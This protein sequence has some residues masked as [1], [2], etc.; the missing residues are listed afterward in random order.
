M[1]EIYFQWQNP[2]LR[3]TIYP[4]RKQKLQ[5][6]LLYFKE[7]DLWKQVGRTAV[8]QTLVH[9]L[10]QM[11][12][13]LQGRLEMAKSNKAQAETELKAAAL[14]YREVLSSRPVQILRSQRVNLQIKVQSLDNKMKTVKRSYDWYQE[15]APEHPYYEKRKREYEDSI[16]PY[17]EAKGELERVSAEYQVALGPFESETA[18]LR[19]RISKLTEE[20]KTLSARLKSLPPLSKQGEVSASAAVRWQMMKYEESLSH[21]GQ[22][23]LIKVI[24]GEFKRRPDRFPSW[25]QY[26]II[27]FSGMRYRSAHGS[28][29]NPADLLEA[30]AIDDLKQKIDGLSDSEIEG[31]CQ[32]VIA[33]LEAK[34]QATQ[35]RNAIRKIDG[36]ISR[37]NNQWARKRKLLELLSDEAIRGIRQLDPDQALEQLRAKKDRFPAWAWKEVV[38]R[39]NLRVEEASD[40]NWEELSQK[41]RQES[42]TR[43]NQRWMSML[44][45]WKTK[46]ITQWRKQHEATL[47]LIV[48]RAVCNEVSE[49]IQHLRGV[50]PSA[51]LTSKPV[52]Y[53][54]LQ[55][56]DPR[57]SYFKR[58]T[59]VNDLKQ[60][61][62]ILW[63]GWVNREPNAWQIA[64]P[65][66]GI[67][68]VP[69]AEVPKKVRKRNVVKGQ[70]DDWRYMIE[71]DKFIRVCR[72]MIAIEIERPA[73]K[74]K[75]EE[76]ERKKKKGQ[77]VQPKPPKIKMVR[78][79]L[80]KEWLRWTH[81]AIIVDVVEMA[82]GWYVMTFETGKI[83]LNL[84]P[85]G[86]ILDRWDVYVGY[87]PPAD[88]PPENLAEM[89]DYSRI[90]P[91]AGAPPARPSASVPGVLSLDEE[92]DAAAVSAGDEQAIFGEAPAIELPSIEL[93]WQP[94][95]MEAAPGVLSLEEEAA[96]PTGIKVSWEML[97]RRQQ[98]VV[99]LFC[100]G[101]SAR[102]IAE[103]LEIVPS[104]VHTHLSNIQRKLG[105]K[106]R[107]G[108]YRVMSGEES[109]D[110]S[111]RFGE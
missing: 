72:P 49:H 63:L 50:K 56:N 41:E 109:P 46:D 12:A 31:R 89:I 24:L 75:Q 11:Y 65:L 70:G 6:V 83:G 26:M 105:I 35:D 29:A 81:E 43:E 27:H 91:T 9:E 104:T 2:V 22:D 94:E 45:Y 87:T 37:L 5:D 86:Y 13:G 40:E 93:A 84:R 66:G 98:Q 82:T 34:K 25:L 101:L 33:A 73:S 79:P 97:T 95:A 69:E 57:K 20:I 52:W 54:G 88:V 106:E 39:T 107:Q 21:Y 100:Q 99:G 59:S 47:D 58:P 8:P 23:D 7:I 30:L 102:Q 36:D 74:K 60:G 108:L 15:H 67:N 42:W 32:Q 85:L 62:S 68:L 76:E 17:Q 53:M 14:R 77:P 10:I 71:G 44:N 19:E 80:V 61:A 4:F 38:S 92:E 1:A 90:L 103:R 16:P 48:S 18:G 111:W 96:P 110:L 78:G 64:H 28:W 3:D 55:R 51:G